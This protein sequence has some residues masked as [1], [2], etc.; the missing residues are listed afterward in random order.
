MKTVLNLEIGTGEY[1]AHCS[2][3]NKYM[4]IKND[5]DVQ[6][7]NQSQYEEIDYSQ[8]DFPN[9]PSG[10]GAY[11]L[12]KPHLSWSQLLLW[13]SSKDRYRR[14]YFEGA[15]KLNTKYLKFG[16]NI[17][18]LIENGQ[19]HELIPDLETYDTPEHK[20]ECLVKGVPIL[21][22]LDSY[23]KVETIDVPANVFRE[24]K[25][26]KIPWTKAKVQKHDQL[27]FYATAL[28]W[29]HGEA[30]EYCD[31]DWIETKDTEKIIEKGFVKNKEEVQV[32]GRVVSF[33]REF[34]EREIERMEDL[35][36]KTAEE[37][38][39]AYQKFIK[40]I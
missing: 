20:I 10:D 9:Y 25:T 1:S 7:I 17:A 11:L 22:F 35:I 34:D 39:E 38:S 14:E 12:P 29:S 16:S 27:V 6:K 19:H 5:P 30:P 4:F 26:G 24:Y 18:T 36:V 21:S 31:L 37:I 23:N 28:K 33:H 3:R 2:F 8:P 32:T 40:E 13:K 15:K